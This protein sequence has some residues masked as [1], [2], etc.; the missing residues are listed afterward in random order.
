LSL[1]DTLQRLRARA[2]ELMTPAAPPPDTGY[3][4]PDYLGGVLVKRVVAYVL[5]LLFIM[6]LY[7]PVGAAAAVLSVLSLG[8]MAPLAAAVLA[9]V[10][11]AYHTLTIGGPHAATWGMRILSI[12]VRRAE[13]GDPT[14]VQAFVQTAL[15]YLSVTVTSSLVLLLAL[16]TERHRTLHDLVAGTVVVNR[17]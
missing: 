4:P 3:E 15:F 8:T 14:Y 2:V 17:V 11:L 12:E 7:L 1:D 10:P 6:L 13:G 9:A 5:D 16:F